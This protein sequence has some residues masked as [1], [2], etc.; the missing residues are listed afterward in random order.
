MKTLIKSILMIVL[1]F[2]FVF[3]ADA[4]DK[5]VTVRNYY[6]G[7]KIEFTSLAGSDSTGSQHSY[8]IYIGD[9]ND[10]DAYG[11]AVTNAASDVNVLIHFSNDLTKWIAV[12]LA[13]LD[14]VSTTVKQ[15]TLGISDTNA[16]R[17]HEFAYMV[18]EHDFQAGANQT[19]QIKT[20]FFLR[21]DASG[22]EPNARA[23]SGSTTNP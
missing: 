20:V 3:A 23:E 18:I 9:C 19:D 17:F 11:Y 22:G 7:A 5:D 1:M 8:P 14:A 15:D 21:S 12:T 10:N 2:T 13:S 4:Y 6:G 16:N